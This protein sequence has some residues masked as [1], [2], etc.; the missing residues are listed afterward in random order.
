MILWEG[1]AQIAYEEY[2]SSL[3]YK[4][5]TVYAGWKALDRDSQQ[6]W[7]KVVQA[8]VEAHTAA[9]LS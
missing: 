9:V 5:N 6:R 2:V 4:P 1:I 7:V 8:A 3:P